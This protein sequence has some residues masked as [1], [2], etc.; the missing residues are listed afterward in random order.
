MGAHI[1]VVNAMLSWVRR[2]WKRGQE[3]REL[4]KDLLTCADRSLG[5]HTTAL[6]P[7]KLYAEDSASALCH[8]CVAALGAMRLLRKSNAESCT[9]S[10][11]CALLVA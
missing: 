1:A 10:A 6:F 4:S 2:G 5:K 8:F 9:S 11:G 3:E 7:R